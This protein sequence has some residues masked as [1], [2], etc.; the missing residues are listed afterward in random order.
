MTFVD[1]DEGPLKTAGHI[2]RMGLARGAWFRDPDGDF[3]G[4]RQR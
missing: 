1:D 3:L 4:L 2:A